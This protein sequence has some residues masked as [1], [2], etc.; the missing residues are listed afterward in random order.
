MLIISAAFESPCVGTLMTWFL[1]WVISGEKNHPKCRQHQLMSWGLGLN[2][3]R[4]LADCL[5]W[6]LP[7]CAL[8]V[9]SCAR[10]PLHTVTTADH[11]LEPW[12]EIIT[13]PCL[14]L[15]VTRYCVTVTKNVTNMP[16][17]WPTRL[18]QEL[19]LPYLQEVKTAS[20]C[21]M[22]SIDL[23]SRTFSRNVSQLC[24]PIKYQLRGTDG[25]STNQNKIM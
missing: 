12:A 19:C 20:T 18:L 9:P 25:W 17:P 24:H 15:T 14:N 3:R 5:H 1:D 22:S 21:R 10:L 13:L 8:N 16:S 7:D 11:S 4:E 6:R 2:P 23:G